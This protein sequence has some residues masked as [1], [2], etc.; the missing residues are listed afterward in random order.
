MKG[1]RVEVEFMTGIY[2]GTRRCIA[3]LVDLTFMLTAEL[4]TADYSSFDRPENLTV[5]TP[6]FMHQG[7]RKAQTEHPSHT[8]IAPNHNLYKSYF[9]LEPLSAIETDQVEHLRTKHDFNLITH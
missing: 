6:G 7:P 3:R 1:P 9:L 8:I 2:W 5:P 4:L